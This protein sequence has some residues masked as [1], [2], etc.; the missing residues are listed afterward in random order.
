MRVR[1]QT[2]KRNCMKSTTSTCF[3]PSSMILALRKTKGNRSVSKSKKKTNTDNSGSPQKESNKVD[4][5]EKVN[6]GKENNCMNKVSNEE[7]SKV[8]NDTASSEQKGGPSAKMKQ[9]DSSH[10]PAEKAS[11]KDS[12]TEETKEIEDLKHF[13]KKCVKSKRKVRMK[14]NISEDWLH[15]LRAKLAAIQAK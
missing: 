15:S 5:K 10:Q 9:D 13:L 12:S 1:S 6:E 3:A 14:P 4:N 11:S 2:R 7:N 8:R